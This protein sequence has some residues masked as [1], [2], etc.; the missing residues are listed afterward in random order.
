VEIDEVVAT[1]VRPAYLAMLF[2]R[3]RYLA[4][5]RDPVGARDAYEAALRIDPGFAPAREG[6]AALR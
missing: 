6:M 1:K 3:G 5:A 4:A 2:N